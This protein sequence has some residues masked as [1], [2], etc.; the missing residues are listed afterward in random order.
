MSKWIEKVSALWQRLFFWQKPQNPESK[1]FKPHAHHDHALVLSVTSKKRLPSWKQI[2]LFSKL[3]QKKERGIFFVALLVFIVA[4]SVSAGTLLNTRLVRVPAAGGTVTEALI[5]TPKLINPLFAPLNDVDRDLSSLIFSGLFRYDDK[6][7]PVPDLVDHYR[8]TDDQKTLEVTLRENVR[9]HDGEKLDADDVMF[10]FQAI[11]N[12]NW[13]SPL[14][15]SFQNV[16]LVR[17]DDRTVQFQLEEPRP[18]FLHALTV[19]ILPAHIWSNVIES[20]VQVADANIRPIGSGPYKVSSFSRDPNGSILSY[21]LQRFDDY[22]G[23]KPY[24]KEWRFRFFQDRDQAFAALKNNQ[25]D[26]LAF[27]PWQ[28]ADQLSTEQ[29]NIAH[30]ELPQMTIAFFNMK[31]SLLK[32][33]DI[34]EA[35]ALATD[36]DELVELLGDRATP[37]TSPF[38]FIDAATSTEP[39][40]EKARGILDKLGW[41]LNEEQGLRFKDATSTEDASSTPLTISISVP[42]QP[43]L[44]HVAEYLK[45]RW[46]LLG[47]NVSIESQS[48]ETLVQRVVTDRQYQVLIWNILFTPTLDIRPVWHSSKATAGGFNFSNIEDRD[49]DNAIAAIESATTTEALVAARQAAIP[50]IQKRTPALFISQPQYAY[51]V[52]KDVK[53]VENQRIGRPSDRFLQAFSWYVKT[54][55][56]WK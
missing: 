32:N 44:V 47:A 37:A 28:D 17:V 30:I 46:S 1:E 18:L 9:F 49:I 3:L 35:L 42:D 34:R 8:W 52:A 24:I 12:P 5:G 10:T 6:L 36:R 25:V 19:G 11:K 51:A 31:D 33:D 22:Y 2:S 38:P 29:F 15:S 23:I 16:T 54:G 56:S 41:K 4:V 14:A 39:D 21:H 13:R 53:G 20:G 27:V 45:R 55:L 48:A 43:D 26:S 40:L 50:I 7:E